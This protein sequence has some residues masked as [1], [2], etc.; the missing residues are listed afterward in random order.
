[1]TISHGFSLEKWVGVES[2]V[3]DLLEKKTFE[4]KHIFPVG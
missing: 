1:M 2:Q 4:A 3:E